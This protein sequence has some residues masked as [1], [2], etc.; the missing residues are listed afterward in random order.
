MA[1]DRLAEVQVRFFSRTEDVPAVSADPVAV[2][3]RLGRRGLSD[4][5][6]ALRGEPDGGGA[7]AQFS[8]LTPGGEFLRTSLR[9]YLRA[10]GASAERVLE[11][12]YV[13]T[14]P[15]PEARPERPHP[16]WVSAV[17]AA[18]GL[19]LTGCYDGA[20]R[21]FDAARP[22]GEPLHAGAGHALAVRGLAAAEGLLLSASKDRTA[23][24]WRV[25]APGGGTVEAAAVL[26]GHTEAVECVA[27]A[28]GAA[29]GE[30]RAVTGGWDRRVLLWDAGADGGGG[31]GE[32][33]S[34][35][36]RKKGGGSAAA[37]A[38]AERREPTAEAGQHAGAVTAAC[39]PHPAA[40]YTASYDHSVRQWDP[41]ACAE[42]TAWHGSTV[43]SDVAF[44]LDANLLATAHNDGGVR[45]WDP[46]ERARDAPRS[47][48]R[49]H[50]GWCTAVSWSPDSAFLLCSASHDGTVKVWDTRSS[51]P[52]HTL[53][54]HDDKALCALWVAGGRVLSGGA[55]KLL[56][57]HAV[58]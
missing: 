5:V 32:G 52:L 8:F 44:S 6:H 15:E 31:G 4:V 17:A 2:P 27:L 24:V 30:A 45:L 43:V 22:G 23:R 14:L 41:S 29:A 56:R 20:V 51:A 34:G 21:S 19:V 1:A 18:G 58:V 33:P 28:P 35:K 11:L 7:A 9:K 40:A 54:A 50:K 46:R 3:A 39:W 48:L 53:A 10:A 13:E 25:D 47:T 37:G 57:D 42:V 12:E 26:V 38:E 49:S 55:D 36:R 16:D